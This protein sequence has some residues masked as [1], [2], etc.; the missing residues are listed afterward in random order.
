MSGTRLQAV[1]NTVRAA[2]AEAAAKAEAEAE[3]A[4]GR[5]EREV[6]AANPSE[7][8]IALAFVEAHPDHRYV[9][10]WSRWLRWDGKRWHEDSTGYVY[11]RIRDLVREAVTGGKAERS[12]ANASFVGGVERLLRT[13]QRL[14][15]VPDQLDADPW[16]LNTQSGVVD[17]RTGAVR[18]HDPA[19]LHTRITT[20]QVDPAEGA[21]L[22]A[23]FLDDITQGD[24]EL[25]RYLQRLA[26]YCAT[27]VT[28]E[29][30]LVYLFG[31]GANGKGSFAE[32]IAHVLGDYAK[33]FPAEVLMDRQRQAA[34][35]VERHSSWPVGRG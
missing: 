14:V 25:Q 17:L 22:W 13:D 5:P 34:W 30:V 3:A 24:V 20:C 27:G 21:A 32:S 23:G 7:D 12:T 4:N 8:A 10:P 11:E 35:P 19:D 15:V 9:A 18:A 2:A 28:P 26:G 6:G 16:A 29:D 31:I 1:G 33:A